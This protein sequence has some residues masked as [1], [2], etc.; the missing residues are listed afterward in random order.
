[1][2]L[3]DKT[4]VMCFGNDHITLNITM[5]GK[6]LEQV[7]F[8]KFVGVVVDEQLKF[9][10]HTEYACGKAKSALNK[11]SI[12]LKGR[13]GLSIDVAIKLYKNLICMHLEYSASVWMFKSSSVINDI[14]AVQHKSLKKLYG[15]FQ[16]SSG[17]AL[18][19]ITGVFPIDL[20]LQKICRREWTRI[21]ALNSNH[22]LRTMLE[23]AHHHKS[24]TTPLSYLKHCCRK[25]EQS[26]LMNSVTIKEHQPIIPE[27]ITECQ[28]FHGHCG[29]E[30]NELADLAAK[31]GCSLSENALGM[32]EKLSYST[33]SKWID[34]LL[35]Q[36]WQDRWLRCETG[37]STKE[38]IP[39]VP[40]NIRIPH[41]RSIGIS[42][43]R[44]LLDNAAV[45]NNLFR[46]KLNDDPNCECGKG[47]QTVQHLILHCDKFIAERLRLK[48][49]I[50]SIWFNSKR[51][52]NLNFDLKLLLNPWSTKL[53]MADAKEVAGEFERFLQNID[54]IF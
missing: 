15:A 11:V 14:R 32:V 46:M 40:A 33:L 30:Y 16:S 48:T 34:E 43:V 8:Y 26:M 19:A 13:F 36:E 3:N 7:H 29:I 6:V 51:P 10:L 41:N 45:A 50:G 1:M 22:P 38:I 44:C 20:R 24:S 25:I 5:N 42:L 35:K 18:E 9:D 4:K 23:Q 21:K 12:L 28:S 49:K 17:D 2:E 39:E 27:L 47:R 54:F 52:G 53:N 37:I 31:K